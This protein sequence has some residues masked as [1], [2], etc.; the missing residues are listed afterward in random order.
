MDAEHPLGLGWW[1]KR[2]DIAIYDTGGDVSNELVLLAEII[3]CLPNLSIITFCITAD[4]YRDAT[5]P[6]YFLPN[7]SKSTGSNLKAII[8]F[9]NHIPPNT[10]DWYT[11]LRRSG[12]SIRTVYCPAIKF[13]LD[14]LPAMP[15]VQT[16]YIPEALTEIQD[17]NPSLVSLRHA[18]FS[19]DDYHPE[20]NSSG[21][22][23]V[24]WTCGVNLSVIQVYSAR[25]STLEAISQTCFNLQR[26][27]ISVTCWAALVVAPSFPT[28][29]RTLGICSLQVQAPREDVNMLFSALTNRRK[30]G[31]RLKVIQFL[32]KGTVI[33]LCR[34]HRPVLSWGIRLLKD[35][36][37]EV[38]DHEGQ[39]L[40]Y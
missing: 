26:L 13:P 7:L 12:G 5:L 28:S 18:I 25:S 6:P 1:T 14:F 31:S 38:H 30:F 32:R 15:A 39:V 23:Q 36:G 33:D 9:S 4:R 16:F 21:W 22:K 11:F 17:Y 20:Y 8:W 2:F 37:I 24:L 3:R 10:D 29:I 34:N 27:D 19:D 35:R 40:N